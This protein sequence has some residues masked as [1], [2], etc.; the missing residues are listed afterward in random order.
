MGLFESMV[1]AEWYAD[2]ALHSVGGERKQG[3]QIS[4][5]TFSAFRSFSR[6]FLKKILA[7]PIKA[8]Q[9]PK[10]FD[11]HRRQVRTKPKRHEDQGGTRGVQYGIGQLLTP[12]LLALQEDVS[13]HYGGDADRAEDVRKR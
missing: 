3:A 6:L 2:K 11:D 12:D 7:D 13:D 5:R 8:D 1:K 10:S 9:Q 4:I